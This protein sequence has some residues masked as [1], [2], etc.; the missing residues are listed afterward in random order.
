MHKTD[1]HDLLNRVRSAA[2]P[3]KRSDES[4]AELAKRGPTDHRSPHA[5]GVVVQGL[6]TPSH[7]GRQLNS[8]PFHAPVEVFAR[9]SLMNDNTGYP[10]APNNYGLA[11]R[12][13]HKDRPADLL[14]LNLPLLPVTTADA[15]ERL[16]VFMGEARRRKAPPVRVA[17]PLEAAVAM[18]QAS[19]P[20][21]LALLRAA[22][23]G[24][25]RSLAE[26]TYHSINALKVGV[27]SGALLRWTQ[28]AVLRD[29]ATLVV[30]A[31]WV[32]SAGDRA[33]GTWSG[34]DSALLDPLL[35]LD[36]TKAP[37]RF[38]LNFDVMGP[39]QDPADTSRPWPETLP[40]L[41]VGQMELTSAAPEAALRFWPDRPPAGFDTVDDDE[42]MNTRGEVYELGRRP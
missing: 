20:G 6:F 4:T 38:S 25:P 2:M 13:G 27:H 34:V 12:F 40:R 35:A 11:V 31:R 15:F 17:G 29:D 1:G 22:A 5:R 3:R 28:R 39:R 21:T 26:A 16:V 42:I 32:P 10:D 14:T 9:F 33:T 8:A 41:A 19:V 36:G 23:R 7:C 37:I 30:R 18:R 24:R